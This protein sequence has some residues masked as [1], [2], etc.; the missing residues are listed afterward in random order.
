MAPTSVDSKLK[1]TLRNLNSC[2]QLHLHCRNAVFYKSSIFCVFF[3]HCVVDLYSTIM[4]QLG[5]L[6]SPP[7][8]TT[9]C[10]SLEINSEHFSF[11]FK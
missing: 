5:L 10:M 3:F 4:Q 8:T 11:T 2:L 6:V 7:E 9:M 1:C